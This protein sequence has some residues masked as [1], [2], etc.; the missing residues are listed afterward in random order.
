MKRMS[1]A[2]Y[3]RLVFVAL[4]PRASRPVVYD[5]V[6]CLPFRV[7]RYRDHNARGLT[8][9]STGVLLDE[10][11]LAVVAGELKLLVLVQLAGVEHEFS[12]ALCA[13]QNTL[14]RRTLARR[15][16]GQI[17]QPPWVIAGAGEDGIVFDS[18]HVMSPL[19]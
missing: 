7:P 17:V 3:G 10:A 14:H 18:C 15:V 19:D 1:T 5:E 8:E 12:D 4:L 2:Q 16:L 11:L 6:L 13:V 9:D